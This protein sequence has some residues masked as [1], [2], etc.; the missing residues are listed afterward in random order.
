[1]KKHLIPVE[2]QILR[3][4]N[5]NVQFNII[6]EEDAIGFLKVSLYP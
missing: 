6:K 4:K 1:M 2:E 3:L 5:K